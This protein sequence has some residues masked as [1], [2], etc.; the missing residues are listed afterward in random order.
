MRGVRDLRD[1]GRF[2]LFVWGLFTHICS[3]GKDPSLS[4]IRITCAL[5]VGLLCV[6]KEKKCHKVAVQASPSSEMWQDE[7]GNLARFGHLRQ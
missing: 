4:R 5:S 7:K 6:S 3:L 1:A 2:S